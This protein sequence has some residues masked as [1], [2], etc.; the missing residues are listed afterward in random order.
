MPRRFPHPFRRRSRPL[1]PR[2]AVLP[3]EDSPVHHNGGLPLPVDTPE[4]ILVK[5]PDRPQERI[6]VFPARIMD[7]VERFSPGRFCG[8]RTDAVEMMDRLFSRRVIPEDFQERGEALEADESWKQVVVGVVTWHAPTRQ[9]WTYRR[10]ATEGRL[11]GKLSC[12]IGGHVN[13]GDFLASIPPRPFP[14][15]PIADMA[16]VVWHAGLRELDEEAQGWQGN[17]KNHHSD[18]RLILMGCVNDEA[19]HVGRCHFGVLYR[20]DLATLGVVD[21]FHFAQETGVGAGWMP[22]SLVAEGI[23]EDPH[24]VQNDVIVETWSQLVARHLHEMAPV[25]SAP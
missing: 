14:D 12:I 25:R 9:V 24:D 11:T 20:L 6:L 16:N 15:P 23:L 17:W 22:S 5:D 3:A 7:D 8:V 19:D 13:L 1:P 21:Q 2:S 10:G 18:C 4:T